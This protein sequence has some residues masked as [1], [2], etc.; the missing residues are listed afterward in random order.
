MKA[1]ID[2]D[3]LFYEVGFAGQETKTSVEKI[4]G[5]F[6]KRTKTIPRDW[7]LVKSMFDN[8]I[9]QICKEVGATSPPLLFLTNTE[10][11]NTLLNKKRKWQGDNIINFVPNFREVVAT[12]KKYKGGRKEEKPFHYKNLISYVIS[13]YDFKVAENGLEADDAMCIY[14]TKA[15]KDGEPTIIC[16]RDKDLRQCAGNHFSWEC[17]KQF[18]IGPLKVEGLGWLEKKDNGKIFGVGEKFFYYQLL[19]GDNVDNIVGVMGRGPS[20][21]YKLLKDLNSEQECYEEVARVYV[22][23]FGN[24]WSS[25]FEEMVDLLWIIKEEDEEGNPIRWRKFNV[26]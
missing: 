22:Q 19:T 9:E 23:A 25:K 7:E 15:M 1:L 2:S 14:Q 13:N 21:A 3:I 16:S 18:A 8:K 24:E 5:E 17:G 6:Y 26:V 12:T 4:N 20:F 10:Y 11:V